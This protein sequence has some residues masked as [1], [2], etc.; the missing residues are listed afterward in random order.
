MTRTGSV[1][2]IGRSNVG[3][4]T[5]LNAALGE[6]LAIVSQTAQTTRTALLGIVHGPLGELRLLDTPGLHQPRSE[7]GRRMNAAAVESARTADLI[8]YM[9]DVASLETTGRGPRRPSR[10]ERPLVFEEDRLRVLELPPGIPV[11]LAVNKVD[12][13]S[14]K[15]RL[16]P[17]LEAFSRLRSFDELVPLSCREPADV[18]RLLAL[19]FARLGEGAPRHAEDE[20]TDRPERYFVAEYIREQVLLLTEREVPHAVA[21]TVDTFEDQGKKL[22]IRATLHVEKDGQRSILIGQGGAMI[23]SIGIGAR[24]RIQTLLGRPARLELFVRTTPHWKEVPRQLAELGYDLPSI[25]AGIDPR[26]SES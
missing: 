12:R 16:L 10:A 13:L 22:L 19:L 21:V 3:K 17:L 6:P 15:S 26:D 5:F 8:L 25:T 11:I 14:D 2:L 23:R 24:R 18:E 20:L 1:A 7:L 4:S 9:T